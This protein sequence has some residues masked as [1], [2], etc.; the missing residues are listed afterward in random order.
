MS[1]AMFSK[2][3]ACHNQ[4][5]LMAGGD[6]DSKEARSGLLTNGCDISCDAEGRCSGSTCTH[7]LMKSWAS[8][9][10]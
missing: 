6:A 2:T 3:E 1:S 9:D 5:E 4:Y 7:W 10:K 8:F